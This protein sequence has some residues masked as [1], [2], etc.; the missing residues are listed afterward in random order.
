MNK[1]LEKLA[2]AMLV[3]VAVVTCRLALAQ[4]LPDCHAP[5]AASCDRSGCKEA[6]LRVMGNVVD[7]KTGREFFLDYPCDLKPGEPVNFIL[8]LHGAN[9]IANWVRHYFPAFDYKEQ[10]R[11][12]IA[13]P[14]AGTIKP[15]RVW[16][17]QADEQ[18]LQNIV[19]YVMARFGRR[20]IRSFWLAGHSQGGMASNWLVCTNYFRDKVDGWL[21]LSGG[22]FG[23]VGIPDDFF[24]AN[25]PPHNLDGIM[26]KTG[27]G[28]GKA[29]V[30]DCAFSYIF[31]SGDKEITGLPPDSPWADRF[32]CKAR[33]R[34]EDVVD[35][36][37]GYVAGNTGRA[38]TGRTARPGTA[39]VYRYPGCDN[40]M[41]VADVV[42]HDKGH[43]E[44]LEPEVTRKL[45]EMMLAAP[46]GKMQ[47]SP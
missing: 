46:A 45:I 2:H 5:P 13:T 26:A 30:P 4:Q 44:G 40:G 27:T 25:G 15:I 41:L 18:P 38:S 14:S 10:Y 33:T 36:L 37:P 9:S 43:T 31:A 3:I 32:H 22:R 20:N 19:D 28:F 8:A 21:S 39:S 16:S 6:A 47:A 12:V 29:A 23:A 1:T 11:L 24:G 42:R 17:M 35:V 7:E 34:L